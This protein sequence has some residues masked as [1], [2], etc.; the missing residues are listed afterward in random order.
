MKRL[1]VDLSSISWACLFAGKDEEFGYTAVAPNGK[2]VHINSHKHGYENA[3]NALVAVWIKEDIS[4]KDT[5]LVEE[6][7]NSTGFRK[8]ILPSYKAGR[9]DNRPPEYFAEFQKLKAELKTAVKSVGGSS[10]CRWDMEADDTIAYLVKH[11]DGSKVVMSNDGDLSVLIDNSTFMWRKGEALYENPYGPFDVKFLPVYKA[12]VG[13]TSDNIPGAKGFGDKAFLSL[14]TVFGEEGLTEVERLIQH[15]LLDELQENVEDLKVLQK[16]IDQQENVYASYAVGKL[17]PE[18]V[19][20]VTRP[21]QWDVGFVSQKKFI[22]DERLRPFGGEIKLVHAGNLEESVKFFEA[23]IGAS[24]H[25][26]LD[27]ETSM[28]QE[29]VDWLKDLKDTD[30]EDKIGVDVIGSTL[31]GLSI[32]FGPN[33]SKTLYFAVDHRE[34]EGVKNLTAQQVHEFIKAIPQELPI[35]VHN[36]GFEQP[37]LYNTW[38]EGWQD[39]GWHGFLPNVH[40]T[41]VLANY[42]NENERAGLKHLSKLYFDYDQITYDEVTQGRRMN[43]LTAQEVLNYGADDTIMTSALYDHFKVRCELD[44]SWQAFLD[45]EVKPAYVTALAFVQGTKLDLV[46]MGKMRK[47]DEAKAETLQKTIDTFL[48]KKG[49]EGTVCPVYTTEDLEDAKKLKEIFEHLTGEPLKTQVRTPSKII[50]LV[51]AG[52]EPSSQLDKDWFD[53]GCQTFVNLVSNNKVD[54]LNAHIKS[55]FNGRPI[56]D[57]NS[58]KQVNHLLY[59]VLDLP[60]RIVNS[61]TQL[62]REKNPELARAVYKFN[63]ILRGSTDTSPL[64]PEE[65]ELLKQKASTDDT[66]IA[67]ALQENLQE[68]VREF[69]NAMLELKT[70]KTRFNMFYTKYENIEHWKT[71]N[72]HANVRLTSTTTRRATSSTPNLQQVPKRGEGK[73][74]RGIFVPHRKNGYIVSIDYNAQEIRCQAELS[75][76]PG[77][78]ACYVGDNKKDF[79]SITA[80]QTMVTNWGRETVEHLKAKYGIEDLYDLFVARLRSEDKEDAKK[81]DALRNNAK[82]INFSA[83]YGTTAPTLAKVLMVSVEEAQ[84]NL[85]AKFAAFPVYEEWKA[86]EEAQVLKKGYIQLAS[87]ARRHLQTQVMSDNSWEREKAQRQASNF[88]IQGTCA[89]Q[90][91][92]AMANLWDSGALF[93]FDARFIAPIHD[94]L[95]CS[96]SKEDAFEFIKV[97]HESMT[98]PFLKVVPVVAEISFGPNFADQIEVGETLTK[99][100]FEKA[101]QEIIKER[102]Y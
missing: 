32:T 23:H 9:N 74:F 51:E 76:D 12:L 97:L 80:S 18:L 19:E 68:D 22:K 99:E 31:N 66:A 45:I 8:K 27:I 44:G 70:I 37:I 71:G 64:T 55:N 98:K 6:E 101:Q 84:K 62:Q 5:I 15:R 85:D 77:L 60:I 47:E 75:Q 42:V 34:A 73:K 58:P 88:W 54:E 93:E 86:R 56:F 102:G 20:D 48:V 39:N 82:P 52:L 69:L 67:Y 24:Q 59:T 16:V 1:I 30:D 14:L 7:G 26:A 100:A 43:Q 50:K 79:H 2:P 95:V 17:Y 46:K 91:K 40:D 63:K 28:E 78:L 11:L 89:E 33:Q 65:Q 29:A 49:W 61:L 96:V 72:L 81:A 35:V 10:V 87:G 41:V 92:L 25:V 53:V 90:T 94:E 13:D 57:L 38:G 21:L 4:P 83:S 36:A 3:I